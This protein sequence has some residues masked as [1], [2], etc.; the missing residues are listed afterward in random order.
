[1]LGVGDCGHPA[2]DGV[3]PHAELYGDVVFDAGA[4]ALV[5]AGQEGEAVGVEH[6]FEAGSGPVDPARVLAG[7]RCFGGVDDVVAGGAEAGGGVVERFAVEVRVPGHGPGDVDRGH[8]VS[9]AW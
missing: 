3:V 6:S 1:R 5:P 4:S 8:L 9:S 2:V 7:Y